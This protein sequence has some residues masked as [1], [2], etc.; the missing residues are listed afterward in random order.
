MALDSVDYSE[1]K[2]CKI[3][4]IVMQDDKATAKAEH[5]HEIK[6]DGNVDNEAIPNE[7]TD[8]G[9]DQIDRNDRYL[10]RLLFV[11]ERLILIAWNSDRMLFFGKMMHVWGPHQFLTIH[12]QQLYTPFSSS[13]VIAQA[14]WLF[15]VLNKLDVYIQF[16][17]IELPSQPFL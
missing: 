8:S 6:G 16:I 10:L 7:A 3:L 14:D 12:M 11:F 4:E 5:T 13:V 17:S 9:T 1:E 15:G 2:A